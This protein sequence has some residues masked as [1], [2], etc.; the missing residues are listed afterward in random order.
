LDT[1]P[2]A[3]GANVSPRV[4]ESYAGGD[5]LLEYDDAKIT[6][7]HCPDLA[8]L[9]GKTLVVT[10]GRTLLG[11]DD[12]SGVATIMELA[13][14]LTTHP[15]IPHG[16]IRIL[17]TCDEEIG[18]GTKYIPFS[19]IG[20][21]VGYT[22]DG[23]GI[24]DIDEE[25]FSADL[26]IVRFNGKNIHPSIAKNRMVNAVRAAGHFLAI[27]PT[28]HLSPEST[29]DRQGFLHPY[30]IHGGVGQA[31]LHLILRDFDT[32]KLMDYRQ[33][34]DD[35]AVEVESAMP[36]LR[37]QVETRQQYR[38]MAEGLRKLP[39]AVALAEQAYAK[40][41]IP[42]KRSIVRGGTDGAMLTEMG[43]PTPNLSVGQ[44]NIHSVLEFACLDHMVS[45]TELLIELIQLWEQNRS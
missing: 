23:S 21:R 17:F 11:G 26:A 37:I 12:K 44:Y 13:A 28:D 5:I 22:L 7:E 35:L 30:D 39:Q 36:G 6:V 9:V 1:S 32:Q 25:T 45:A 42:S 34:L 2:E 41:G 31:T 24:G 27:L 14:C 8:G 43:L 29:H 20:A 4:I 38:N 16:P 40:L 33:L 10:D 19:K 3:P 18:H 15:E